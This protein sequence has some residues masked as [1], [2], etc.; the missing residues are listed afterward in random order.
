MPRFEL[1]NKNQLFLSL[2]ALPFLLPWYASERVF[3]YLIQPLLFKRHNLKL[4]RRKSLYL[5]ALIL[6]VASLLIFYLVRKSLG[7]Y[8]LFP[9]LGTAILN[10]KYLLIAVVNDL[11]RILQVLIWP[12]N[13]LV[14][15]IKG[16]EVPIGELLLGVYLCFLAMMLTFHVVFRLVTTSK[17][18]SKAVSLRNKAVRRVDVVTYAEAAQ[19]DELFV[20]IDTRNGNTPLFAKRQW[21]KGHVQVVGAAGSGKTESI[22]QPLWF[23]E[24]RR[25]VATF[26]LDGEG[27][28]Q[29]LDKI[30]TVASSLA[31]GHEVRY[32]NPADSSRSATYNP[33][34]R[35][36]AVE[37]KH[38][39]MAS[40]NWREASPGA[41]EHV[42]HYLDLII[43]TI[44]ARGRFVSLDEINRYLSDKT[45]LR[46]QLRDLESRE[47]YEG[48]LAAVEDYQ[49][50]QA[51]TKFLSSLLRE[52]CHA[53][54]AWLLD[55][56]EPEIDVL[57]TYDQREDCYFTLP[58]Q[59]GAPE[60]RFLGQLILQD[61]NTCL[62]RAAK[63]AHGEEQGAEGLLIIDR[64]KNFANHAFIDLL[65]TCRSAQVCVCYTNQSFAEL[66]TPELGL[67]AAFVNELADNTNATFSFNLGSPESIRAVLDRIGST[68]GAAGANDWLS[69]DMLKNLPIGHCLASFRQ[70]RIL[71][72][73]KTGYFQFDNLM[74]YERSQ[75]M[76]NE[77]AP[78]QEAE[79]VS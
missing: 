30:Y 54:Y 45:Y 76:S 21:L 14:A 25:N 8:A 37:I 12:L 31:Q 57:N 61:M 59:G 73:L 56:D 5:R 50:Y 51:E 20:G 60:M 42:S 13:R 47:L 33:L 78:V 63:R 26:V 29:G 15:F 53:E 9:S 24:V 4:D 35:G 58:M 74:H 16:F 36:T 67:G 70:P 68:G 46:E 52:I 11:I 1:K 7:H 48:L 40:L 2:L 34:L 77:V 64:L 6:V 66:E 23:Q 19:P 17:S 27:S 22:V 55:T 62:A 10:I 28:Q 41:K 18:L 79:I 65:Q 32:F 69:E 38:K 75:E 39:I 43:R 49:K 71:T 44:V 3:E 72:I